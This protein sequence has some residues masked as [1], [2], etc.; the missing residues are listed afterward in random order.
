MRQLILVGL[1]VALF[2]VG[3]AS[4]SAAWTIRG[5][6]LPAG[7]T[8]SRLE[9]VSC[10]SEKSCW[11]VGNYR[12]SGTL[13]PLAYEPVGGTYALPPAPAG[14]EPYLED[15]SCPQSATNHLCMASGRFVSGGN[16]WA[17]AEK[18]TSTTGWELQTLT[19]PP[20]T[21]SSELGPISC[22]SE[23]ECVATGGYHNS[24]GLHFFAERWTS[25]FGGTWTPE[26]PTEPFGIGYG[27]VSAISCPTVGECNAVAAYRLPPSY[28]LVD[29]RME[30]EKFSSS[31][32]PTWTPQGTYFAPA[33][34]GNSE[35]Y[36]T[37]DS[38][39][40]MTECIGV[41][42]YTNSSGERRMQ[43]WKKI[44][45]G[46]GW[47][48]Q[49]LPTLAGES[50]LHGVSCA[51]ITAYCVAVGRQAAFGG[52]KAIAF[53][54]SGTTW[55]QITLPAVTGSTDSLLNRDSCILKAGFCY[56]VGYAVVGGVT[57]ALV[58]RNF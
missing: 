58:E 57:S 24:T 7:T 15:V 2:G 6:T 25:A 14:T 5:V 26:T 23:N 1:V 28:R 32:S 45:S 9:G 48:E 41:G 39:V 27:Y 11:A 34:T 37:S 47:E 42:F 56:A 12:S 19:F 54:P 35:P 31:P 22:P 20:F 52:G 43:S 16:Y 17:F 33:G 8:E 49:L 55:T 38:C 21:T 10:V 3:C 30:N 50:E 51:T 40:S 46:P 4:A 29:Q 18:Y 13:K 53:E 44:V 36:I